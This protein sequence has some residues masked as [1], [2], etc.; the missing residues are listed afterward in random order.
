MKRR[1]SIDRPKFG[2]IWMCNLP[3]K[4]NSVQKGRR[5]VFIISNDKN[6]T[7]AP[8]VNVIPLTSSK[9]K[10]RIPVHVAIDNYRECGLSAPSTMLVEQIMTVSQD[11]LYAYIGK[12]D[13][14]AIM[15]QVYSA[16]SIQFP[17]ARRATC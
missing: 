7:Y 9:T 4:D 8:T 13:D 10:K 11:D 15:N 3:N 6:N 14:E 16:M 1:E 2:E 17:I 12:I 5:P